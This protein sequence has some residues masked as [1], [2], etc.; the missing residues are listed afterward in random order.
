[1]LYCAKIFLYGEGD[2][3][4][5]LWLLILLL[6]IPICT[7]AVEL[8]Q[9]YSTNVL[10]YDLTEDKILH[11]I[12]AS[13]KR[14]VA[15]LTKIVTTITAIENIP[16]LDQKVTVTSQMLAGIPWDASIAGLQVGDEL[17]IRDVL[18]ASILPSGAD[19]THVL[20]FTSAGSVPKFV[21]KMNELAKKVG[22]ND[23]HF[24]NV[25]GYDVDNHYSTA[26]DMLKILK[27]ALSN[28]TFREIYC[29]K[30]HM[31]SNGK[32]VKA[33]VLKYNETM[34]LDISRILGS[35]TGFT[36]NAGIC[37]SA[38]INSNGHEIIIITLNAPYTNGMAY[39]LIDALSIIKFMDQNYNEQPLLAKEQVV[40]DIDV[41]ISN[42][43][44]L[45]IKGDKLITK[46]L[47]IDYDKDKVKIDYEGKNSVSFLNK[48]GSKL[49][50]LKVYYDGELIGED[51]VILDQKIKLS[52]PKLIKE[53]Y[54]FFLGIII[55]IILLFISHRHKHKRHRK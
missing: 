36:D 40:K 23:T 20:A 31:M 16:D 47:P 27:Y 25:T 2:N 19:A 11:E 55:L 39:N 17:T 7:Y 35:K 18:Y 46:Y 54:L 13:E 45:S 14:N 50:T 49:G 9:L 29:T 12:N 38:L 37:I 34:H 4:K 3:M 42:I 32:I 43:D 48:E 33:T 51:E 8:P 41:K 1:M 15:S 6:I 26:R 24:V 44:K 10:V 22:A 52:I 28:Q 5:K 53:Y 21:D 30:E